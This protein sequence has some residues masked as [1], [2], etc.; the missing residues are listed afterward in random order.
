MRSYFATCLWLYKSIT[1]LHTCNS[2]Q[3]K[4]NSIIPSWTKSCKFL[5]GTFALTYWTELF[6]NYNLKTLFFVFCTVKEIDE[7]KMKLIIF[8]ALFILG[9]GLRIM[10]YRGGKLFKDLFEG[11]GRYCFNLSNKVFK[12]GHNLCLIYHYMIAI[13]SSQDRSSWS[14][15]KKWDNYTKSGQDH[16]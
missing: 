13:Y 15:N 5:I 2:M 8:G 10:I 4:W 3:S 14:H 1:N 12:L 9:N 11:P 16:S 6:D 7:V